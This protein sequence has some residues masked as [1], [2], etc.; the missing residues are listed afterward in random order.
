M[1]AYAAAHKAASERQTVLA[2][3]ARPPLHEAR[4][5]MIQGMVASIAALHLYIDLHLDSRQFPDGL[6]VALLIVPV[7]YAAIHYGLSG[8]APTGLLATLLWLPDLLLPHDQ[9][10]VGSDLVNLALVDTVAFVIGARIEAER[11]AH[12]RAAQAT[13]KALIAESRY[14]HLFES[15][16]SPILV[17]AASGTI[18]DANPAALALFGDDVVGATPRELLAGAEPGLLEHALRDGPSQTSLVQRIGERDYRLRTVALGSGEEQLVQ[19]VL[20]DVTEERAATDRASRYARTVVQAQE[21]ER[22]RIARELHDEPLQFLLHLARRLD[23]LA[24]A[25]EA[26]KGVADALRSEREEVLAGT[27]R[28]REI[29]RS[30]RPPTLD[31]LGLVAALSSFIDD[32]GEESSTRVELL[33]DGAPRRV[34][35]DVELGAFRIAQEAVRNALRHAEARLVRVNVGFTA[36]SLEVAVADDGRGF[37]VDRLHSMPPSK[38]GVLGMQER[39]RS[40]SGTL[41]L[42]SSPERGTCVRARLPVPT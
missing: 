37:D 24:S 1:V 34:A 19:L 29:A 33:V 18:T 16:R 12:A 31:Q 20:E 30:L 15:N 27:R 9:G 25:S 17:A 36:D 40:L 41:E 39:A 14:H 5:W 2:R 32:L 38:L 8:S 11:V 4:F 7:A 35:R 3:M 21:E 6:P 23:M 28:L 13:T 42:H 22:R 10:H 26:G